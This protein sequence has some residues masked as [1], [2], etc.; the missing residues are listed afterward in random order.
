MLL[1]DN[2][3]NVRSPPVFT[4]E[5]RIPKSTGNTERDILGQLQIYNSNTRVNNNVKK[6][7]LCSV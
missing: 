1:E 4:Y 6:L 3:Q 7:K 5:E 2:L